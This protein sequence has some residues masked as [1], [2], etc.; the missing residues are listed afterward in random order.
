MESWHLIKNF[1]TAGELKEFNQ[2]I[3]FRIRP[4]SLSKHSA[5]LGWVHDTE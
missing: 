3:Q 5:E 1:V 4:N 2:L